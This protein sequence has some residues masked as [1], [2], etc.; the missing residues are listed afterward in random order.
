M[1]C[2]GSPPA[3]PTRTRFPEPPAPVP[4]TSFPESLGPTQA[5]QMAQFQQERGSSSCTSAQPTP[6][7][8][9]AHR[10]P[11]AGHSDP[12]AQAAF[13]IR[14]RAEVTLVLLLLLL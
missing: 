11:R 5:E 7:S 2:L 10:D 14:T 4:T 13:H 12:K 9:G 3:P 1:K 6:R 8:N